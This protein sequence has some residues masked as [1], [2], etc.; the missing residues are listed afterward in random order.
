MEFAQF[1]SHY[2]IKKFIKKGIQIP[3]FWPLSVTLSVPDA[4]KTVSNFITKLNKK[5]FEYC[6][7]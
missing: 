7:Y 6:T 4:Q 3:N 1:M 2:K 5:K